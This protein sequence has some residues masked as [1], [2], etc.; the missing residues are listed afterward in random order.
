MFECRGGQKL[1]VGDGEPT[2][3]MNRAIILNQLLISY[4]ESKTERQKKFHRESLRLRIEIRRENN[5]IE[6]NP[7]P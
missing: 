6:E 2:L 1:M 4:D 5:T 7:L 3:V